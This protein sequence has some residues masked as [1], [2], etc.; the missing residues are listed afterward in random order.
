MA[1]LGFLRPDRAR[2]DHLERQ[3]AD[4]VAAHEAREIAF[5]AIADQVKRHLSRTAAIEQRTKGRE[6]STT[7]PVTLAVLSSKFPPKRGNGSEG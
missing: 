5:L 6:Q 3:V 1:L 4:L 7:D 2:L